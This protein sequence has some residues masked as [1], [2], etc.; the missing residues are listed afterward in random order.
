MCIKE[1][2]VVDLYEATQ[3]PSI[4]G[5]AQ[6][7][8]RWF[9]SGQVNPLDVAIDLSKKGLQFSVKDIYLCSLMLTPG[10]DE[11]LDEK[12]RLFLP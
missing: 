1:Q 11:P 6:W 12:N 8:H 5:V 10:I 2:L 7:A 4:K 3:S 9:F